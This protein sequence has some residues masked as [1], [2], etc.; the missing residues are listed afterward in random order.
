[1]TDKNEKAIKIIFITNVNLIN[2]GGMER[3][4]LSFIKY[5]PEGLK[6][7]YNI[8][9]I[10]TGIYDKIRINEA[11]VI[12]TLKDKNVELITL[13]DY[14]K[15]TLNLKI[16]LLNSFVNAMTEKIR[17]KKYNKT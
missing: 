5:M 2:G 13:E 8:K 6:N 17:N 1:M 4:L 16:G 12:Q 7:V 9:I 11:E 14:N 3:T 15:K 10:Q